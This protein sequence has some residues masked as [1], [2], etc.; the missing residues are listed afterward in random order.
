MTSTRYLVKNGVT[1]AVCVNLSH[2]FS[3]SFLIFEFRRRIVRCRYCGFRRQRG[4]V[5]SRCS[6]HIYEA[7]LIE[8]RQ[9]IRLYLA[10]AALYVVLIAYWSR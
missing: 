5:C 10:C 4:V 3:I 2:S 1:A 9:T 8:R 6:F 7:R